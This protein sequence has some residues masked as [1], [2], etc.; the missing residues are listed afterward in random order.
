[1]FVFLNTEQATENTEVLQKETGAKGDLF[2]FESIPVC[3]YTEK[4]VGRSRAWWHTPLIPALW[5][6][7]QVDF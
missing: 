4:L 5:R 1:M 2:V 7:R 3:S 6:Q